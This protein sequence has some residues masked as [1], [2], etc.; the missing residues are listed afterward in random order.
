MNILFVLTSHAKLGDTGADTGF[1][2]EELAAPY[3]VFED[4]DAE[5]TLASLKGGLPPLDPKSLESDS[6]TDATVRFEEDDNAQEAL[7]NTEILGELSADDFDAVFY[8]GGHGPLWDLAGDPDSIALIE[9]TLRA[10]KPL[11]AVCHG[12]AVFLYA[13]AR[14][15]SP[16]VM[17]RCVTG[18]SN[19]EEEEV[20]LTT[21]VPFL[22][23]DELLKAGATYSKTENWHSHVVMDDDLITGQNPASSEAVARALLAELL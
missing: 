4:A 21:V 9:E 8:P 23:E 12:P 15:G 14:D 3:Y 11:A 18:F 7:A 19:S 17:G 22:L 5:I 6:Q 2:L 10:G 16:L 13:K 1:W 20:G